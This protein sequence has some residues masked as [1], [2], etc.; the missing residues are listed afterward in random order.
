MRSVPEAVSLLPVPEAVLLLQSACSPF[1]VCKL[2]CADWSLSTLNDFDDELFYGTVSE[3]NPSFYKLLL[4]IMF[5]NSNRKQ[6]KMVSLD[7]SP[8]FKYT[9]YLVRGRM[10]ILR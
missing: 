1:V 9:L 5:Y 4:V 6:T 10:L 8:L 7:P 3:I 2:N